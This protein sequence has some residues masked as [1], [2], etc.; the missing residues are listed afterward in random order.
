MF[1]TEVDVLVLLRNSNK[2]GCRE[3]EKEMV[4]R[5]SQRNV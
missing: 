3:K 5:T 4:G 1:I 2:A